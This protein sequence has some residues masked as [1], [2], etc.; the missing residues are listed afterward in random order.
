[1]IYDIHLLDIQ[2]LLK[3]SVSLYSKLREKTRFLDRFAKMS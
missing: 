1:M 3:H 2:I